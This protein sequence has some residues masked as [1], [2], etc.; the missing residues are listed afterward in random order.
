MKTHDEILTQALATQ[1][2]ARLYQ[3]VE[4][5][6]EL[7]QFHAAQAGFSKLREQKLQE[8]VKRQAAMI[9]NLE[10]TLWGRK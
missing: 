10:K 3:L 4:Q 6:L 5:A 7:A 8:Q 2:P 9:D 1:D